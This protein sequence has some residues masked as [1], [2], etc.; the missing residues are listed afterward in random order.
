MQ[1]VMHCKQ[2]ADCAIRKCHLELDNQCCSG[3]IVKTALKNGL[4]VNTKFRLQSLVTTAVT[5]C[6]TVYMSTL[7]HSTS[8]HVK[9]EDCSRADDLLFRRHMSLSQ[10]S[11]AGLGFRTSCHLQ[12]QLEQ[13][14]MC[15]KPS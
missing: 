5:T 1:L 3:I 7:N 11:Q 2:C 14:R 15:G 6:S 12:T 8:L 13:S 4:M 9:M 10:A